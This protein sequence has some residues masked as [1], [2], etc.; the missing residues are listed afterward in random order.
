MVMSLV[1]D[2]FTPC[3]STSQHC[4][5]Y[6]AVA[7]PSV[8]HDF[9]G[10]DALPYDTEGAHSTCTQRIYGPHYGLGTDRGNKYKVTH[11]SSVLSVDL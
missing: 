10:P 7:C 9:E 1:C 5:R 4:S 8:Y 11:M 3:E 6:Y 2:S